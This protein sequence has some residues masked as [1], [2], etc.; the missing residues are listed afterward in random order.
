MI[1]LCTDNVRLEPLCSNNSAGVTWTAMDHYTNGKLLLDFNCI[2]PTVSVQL[3]PQ[4]DVMQY[5]RLL[6]MLITMC[7]INHC[8]ATLPCIHNYYPFNVNFA[9]WC[10]LYE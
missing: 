6:L 8:T 10:E 2:N 3:G 7:C 1:H 4:Y 9:E 5:G